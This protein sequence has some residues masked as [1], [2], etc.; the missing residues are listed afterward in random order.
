[1]QKINVNKSNNKKLIPDINL[2]L[3]ERY[4]ISEVNYTGTK[5]ERSLIAE[6]IHGVVTKLKKPEKLYEK[7]FTK[8]TAIKLTDDE[9]F[10]RAVMGQLSEDFPSTLSDCLR[11]CIEYCDVRD[12]TSLWLIGTYLQQAYKEGKREFDNK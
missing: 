10:E 3:D 11:D 12:K 2:L 8:K 4:A 9:Q 1:M 7:K 5:N 6:I